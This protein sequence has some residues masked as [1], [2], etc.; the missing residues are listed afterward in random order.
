[1]DRQEASAE[2]LEVHDAV[3]EMPDGRRM[4]LVAASREAIVATAAQIDALAGDFRPVSPGEEPIPG[5]TPDVVDHAV[6]QI[7]DLVRGHDAFDVMSMLQQYM[8]PPDFAL[9]SESGSTVSDSWAAAEVVALCLLGMGLPTRD[10]ALEVP[11][12]Q[13]I[14]D[15]L[16]SAAVVVHLATVSGIERYSRLGATGV[17]AEGMTS[18]AFRLASHETS[19]RGRQHQSV[20]T[21]INEAVLRTSQTERTFVTELGFTY[22]DVLGTRRAIVD[23]VA[24]TTEQAYAT[25]AQAAQAGGPPDAAAAAAVRA[26]FQ[27]PSELA[28]VTVGQVSDRS[29]LDPAV[30][31]KVLDLFSIAPDGRTAKEL[32]RD[33]VDGRNPI[34]GIAVLHDPNRGYLPL[35]GALALDEIRR[36]CEAPIK[37]TRSWTQYGRARDKAVENLVADSLETLL[38]NRA[39]VHRNLRYRDA[40]DQQDLSATAPHPDG[41]PLTEADCLLVMD[42]VALCVEVKAGDLRPRTR[43]GGLSQ[44]SGDLNKTIRDAAAQADRLRSLITDHHGLWLETGGWLDL[45]DVQ[46]IYSL[47]VCLDDLGPLA[48]STSELVRSG[49]L[50]Q[51]HLPWVV[52]VHDLLVTQHVLDRPEHFL[53]YLRRRTNR[54]AAMWITGSDE[55]DILMWFISGGFYFVPD[56]DRIHEQHPGS[57][58]PTARMRK[59]Y[60]DQ[61]RTIVGTLTDPLDAHYYYVDGSSSAPADCPR[62][63]APPQLLQDL[64]DAMTGLGAPG[65]WRVGA[66]IDGY[67]TTTQNQM[68]ENIEATLARSRADGAF[69]TFTTGGTDDTGRWIYIFAAGPDTPDNQAHLA[70]YLRAKKHQD[71]ADRALGVLLSRTG[72]PVRTLWLAHPPEEDPD[73][74]ALARAMRLIP[75]DRAPT[76]VPPKAKPQRRSKGR[77]R[78]RR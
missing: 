4:T 25:V 68:A 78:R 32:V 63:S 1:M 21:V 54:D 52:S 3:L 65:W 45:N 15:L 41:A 70:E 42:G 30:V 46:E 35:P 40:S 11:T 59:E 20:A 23:T 72:S 19:V 61:G 6:Q 26:L 48:L 62:R 9:W 18:M 77:R 74:D 50:P 28:Q 38:A 69:H 39:V 5:I 43:Q 73:L 67:S 75:P 64:T 36:T 58:P 7:E 12:A 29:G 34:A 27:T 22:D 33:F 14:P 76:A 49:V 53:T 55:L 60:R 16:T 24:D 56:P 17:A 44:L 37:T 47:V 51:R 8:V 66:D 57:R 13:I 31:K 2:P 71:H 10:P